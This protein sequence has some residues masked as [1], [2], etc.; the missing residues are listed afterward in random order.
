[1]VRVPFS[2]LSIL[3][4]GK[5]NCTLSMEGDDL[6]ID[7]HEFDQV[8]GKLRSRSFTQL[9]GGQRRCAELAFSPVRTL[10]LNP[11]VTPLLLLSRSQS[12]V[13]VSPGNRSL[14]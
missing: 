4:Q 5:I 7:F 11:F 14:R 6:Q 10:P 8:S 13:R 2:F 1:V 3:L 12:R 9:S